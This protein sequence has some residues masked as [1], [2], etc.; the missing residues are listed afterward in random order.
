[1]Q[2]NPNHYVAGA[3]DDVLDVGNWSHHCIVFCW[4]FSMR[5]CRILLKA[6][7]VGPFSFVGQQW[8]AWGTKRRLAATPKL[9][10]NSIVCSTHLQRLAALHHFPSCWTAAMHAAPNGQKAGQHMHTFHSCPPMT[11]STKFGWFIF[12]FKKPAA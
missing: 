8:T 10:D 4:K 11:S 2:L 1:V 5:W 12:S 6:R 3:L 7:R 9:L